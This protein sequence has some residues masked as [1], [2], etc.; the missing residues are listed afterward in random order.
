MKTTINLNDVLYGKYSQNWSNEIIISEDEKMSYFQ[1]YKKFLLS[2]CRKG[3]R[4]Y[5]MICHFTYEE[6]EAYG[7]L[8]IYNRVV[9]DLSTMHC[10]YVAGQSYP[11]EIK[12]LKDI[13]KKASK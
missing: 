4:P 8:G 12:V 5:M 9:F 7:Q 13:I 1:E 11:D 2:H 6:L 10:H 3:S